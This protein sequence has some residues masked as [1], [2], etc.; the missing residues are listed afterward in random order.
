[1]NNCAYLSGA[2]DQGYGFDVERDNL[3]SLRIQRILP[4]GRAEADGRLKAGDVLIA[5]NGVGVV[6]AGDGLAP[7]PRHAAIAHG[8]RSTL[9]PVLPGSLLYTDRIGLGRRGACGERYI[10]RLLGSDIYAVCT[11]ASTDFL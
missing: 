10:H 9:S 4:E 2:N 5:I 8:F 7:L 1:M 3:D 11:R 6:S